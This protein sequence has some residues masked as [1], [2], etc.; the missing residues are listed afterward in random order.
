MNNRKRILHVTFVSYNICY[1]KENEEEYF[2]LLVLPSMIV[3]LRITTSFQS[4]RIFE[5]KNNKI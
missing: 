1:S 5:E 2:A 4:S 3:K